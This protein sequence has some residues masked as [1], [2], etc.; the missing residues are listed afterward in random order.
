MGRLA[1]LS[2]D[3]CWFCCAGRRLFAFRD[4]S[5]SVDDSLFPA[6]GAQAT[7]LVVVLHL[8]LAQ[9]RKVKADDKE[10]EFAGHLQMA[11]GMRL[12]CR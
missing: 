12:P 7:P 5:L 9:L 11:D 1:G 2:A 6:N 3:V 10:A 4:D 8:P